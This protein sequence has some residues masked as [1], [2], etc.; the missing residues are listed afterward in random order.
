MNICPKKSETV[1]PRICGILHLSVLLKQKILKLSNKMFNVKEL[2]CNAISIYTRLRCVIYYLAI[3]TCERTSANIFP[4]LLGPKQ[5]VFIKKSSFSE[6]FTKREGFLPD[7]KFI[8]QKE[9]IKA[10]NFFLSLLKYSI[11]KCI[12][13]VL[14][15]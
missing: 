15:K 3:I 11:Y 12:Y 9:K 13:T 10:S 5:K 2:T 8:Y 6:F 1:Y 4:H 7:P 14:D